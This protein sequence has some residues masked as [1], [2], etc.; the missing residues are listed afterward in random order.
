MEIKINL[1]LTRDEAI[2]ILRLIDN[3]VQNGD[4]KTI[5]KIS[6]ELQEVLNVKLHDI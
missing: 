1:S 3:D 5:N 6:E 2:S 4:W